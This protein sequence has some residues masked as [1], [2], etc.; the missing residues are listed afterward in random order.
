MYFQDLIMNFKVLGEKG[1]LILE[2]YDVEK[3]VGTMS[4]HTF[5]EHWDRTMS[6]AYIEPSKK[7]G[8]MQDMVKIQI[9]LSASSIAKLF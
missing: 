1:C 3:G 5:L 9:G 7:T 2:P 8:L 6:V 4:P